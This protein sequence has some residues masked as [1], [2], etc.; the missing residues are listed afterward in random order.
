MGIDNKSDLCKIKQKKTQLN[1]YF[2]NV[3]IHQDSGKKLEDYFDT[4][5]NH[6]IELEAEDVIQYYENK[7]RLSDY[8]FYWE[9]FTSINP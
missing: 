1:I 4:Q 6:S 3:S 8:S 5:T 9:D 2:M 7:T